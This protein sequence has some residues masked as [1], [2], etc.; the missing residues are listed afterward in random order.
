MPN[1]MTDRY[2]VTQ[3]YL[4]TRGQAINFPAEYF[5]TF[6]KLKKTDVFG[7]VIDIPM[8]SEVLTTMVCF[9]NGAANI[10]FNNGGEY[11]GASQKYRNL[12][13]AAHTLVANA[14]QLLP[15]CEKTKRFDLPKGRTNKIFLL[16]KSGVYMTELKA[17]LIPE[18]E[19][20][21]R[22]FYVLYQRVLSEIRSCQL[23]DE[24]DRRN[25]ATK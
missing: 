10:Y 23:K 12:V 5:D 4:M 11:T 25:A 14:G 19:P 22:S 20:E 24:A 15:K 18:T 1:R 2:N 17:G 9:I 3:K 21:L 6:S 13:Q 8:S 16:T 7:V